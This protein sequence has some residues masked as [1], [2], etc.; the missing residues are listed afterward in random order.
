M[1]A[2]SGPKL[3]ELIIDF[4][5]TNDPERMRKGVDINGMVKWALANGV[6]KL[7]RM[8]VDQ[9]G[10]GLDLNKNLGS[11]V[12]QFNRMSMAFIDQSLL[13]TEEMKRD[14]I[15][16]KLHAFYENYDRAKLAGI[17]KIVD[18]A[19][20]KGVHVLNQKLM[21]KYGEDLGD[22]WKYQPGMSNPGPDP[23]PRMPTM[24]QASA[25][26][27]VP[28]KAPPRNIDK[29]PPPKPPPKN[30]PPS[31]AASLPPLP[32]AE[33][34]EASLEDELRVSALPPP[35]PIEDF[36]DENTIEDELAK[37]YAKYD[38]GKLD[39]LE[40]IVP[41]AT[42][43]GRIEF[44]KKLI[45]LYGASLDDLD[46]AEEEAQYT[47]EPVPEPAKPAKPAAPAPVSRPPK[48]AAPAPVS[49][50]PKPAAPAP[51]SKPP[52]PAA[53]APRPAAP[54]NSNQADGACN[55]FRLDMSG[56]AFGVCMCGY[57]KK[58][59]DLSGGG[60]RAASRHNVAAKPPKPSVSAPVASKPPK[61]SLP[62]PAA[63]SKPPKPSMPPP[64]GNAWK[65]PKPSNPPVS[66]KPSKPMA[67]APVP[68]FRAAPI[69]RAASGGAACDNYQ[70]DMTGTSF[71]ICVCGQPRSAHTG[72]RP[73][74][75]A[76]ASNFG[77]RREF[78]QF[79]APALVPAAIPKVS[80][81]DFSNV[82]AAATSGSSGPC[83]NYRLDM[84][85]SSFGVCVCGYSRAEHNRRPAYY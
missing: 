79:Q 62:P 4:Y 69:A 75:G 57:L 9:Y 17:Q 44:N 60:R 56:N 16:V 70:L 84:T 74:A 26:P 24:K 40:Y 3:T 2:V 50:P 61:P 76:P 65:P 51:V 48:P 63:A 1:A 38:P 45:Q 25:P 11:A 8:L 43:L 7:N 59:H 42:G 72:R 23:P 14:E 19:M 34:A 33:E 66:R 31:P 54:V 78:N 83:D 58:E 52:K 6:D 82:A 37:F 21:M 22:D 20:F 77:A 18:F 32:S 85:G 80:I 10:E 13:R 35:P 36:I 46:D 28:P 29:A 15:Y 71:G 41:F 30:P 55:N 12:Q 73:G 47:Y 49:R 64:G 68:Q 5:T 39:A 67:P 81:P 27:K 53:P